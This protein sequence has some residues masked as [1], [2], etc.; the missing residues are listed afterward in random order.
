MLQVFDLAKQDPDSVLSRLFKNLGEA[1]ERGNK[2]AAWVRQKL[3]VL[4]CGGDGTVAWI[5]TAI[6]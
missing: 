1:D 2:Q 6:W 3:R 4:A 5:L